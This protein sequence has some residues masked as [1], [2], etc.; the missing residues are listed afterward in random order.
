LVF[1]Q[2]LSIYFK[3]TREPP[4]GANAA[5]TVSETPP[6]EKSDFARGVTLLR[7]NLK[8]YVPE[9]LSS[10]RY[11]EGEQTFAEYYEGNGHYRDA[12]PLRKHV[13]ETLKANESENSH[14]TLEAKLNY[15]KVIAKN[16]DWFDSAALF[17]ELYQ[18]LVKDPDIT[19][20]N[21]MGKDEGARHKM[22]NE[23]CESLANAMYATARYG[24]AATMYEALLVEFK[25]YK[26]TSNPLTSRRASILCRLADC[27]RL[28][29]QFPKAEKAYEEALKIWSEN[30]QDPARMIATT[31]LLGFV[32]FQQGHYKRARYLYEEALPK[33]ES[34]LGESSPEVIAALREYSQLMWKKGNYIRSV[35]TD[36]R[37]KEL[38]SKRQRTG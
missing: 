1:L 13:Y 4:P 12:L 34:E 33:M 35:I 21:R 30:N 29:N 32:H 2:Y 24:E 6:E 9:G 27:Y 31:R 11:L 26:E 10:P 23:V 14:D 38:Q 3:D 36:L 7:R 16:G 22:F 17:N 20:E 8:S 25:K 15:A 18:N 19:D 28:R 5:W 37:V